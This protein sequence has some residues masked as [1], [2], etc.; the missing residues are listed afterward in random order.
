MNGKMESDRFTLRGRCVDE[1]EE[2]LGGGGKSGMGS[3]GRGGF[4]GSILGGYV[5]VSLSHEFPG[6]PSG[7]LMVEQ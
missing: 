5:S 7:V 4:S 2:T 3:S 6:E 1:L